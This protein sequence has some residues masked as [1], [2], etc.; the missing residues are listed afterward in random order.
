MPTEATLQEVQQF[1]L[2]ILKEVVKLCE[3][4]N[5]TYYL[6]C[7]TLIG[8]VRHKGFIPWDNDIDIEIPVEHYHR[9]LRLAKK[10]LPS[11]LFA[12][13]YTT[14]KG[15]NEMWIKVRANGTTSMPRTWRNWNIHS[16]IAIDIFPLTGI[17]Q[18]PFLRKLQLKCHS[19]CRTL[20]A[21]EFLLA[22]NP[23]EINQ[24]KKLQLIYSMPRWLRAGISR[25]LECFVFKK[26]S[27][28]KEVALIDHRITHFKSVKA[29]A[30]TNKLPFEDGLYS[31]PADPD[32]VLRA[33][34]GDYMTP[35]PE[36]V[37]NGHEW[38]F[39]EIIYSIDTDYSYYQ[40]TQ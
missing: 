12:A 25:C 34:Y 22:T 13:T 28:S 5:I 16:G 26:V 7:G 31:V 17:Y 38:C 11:H 8:A 27:S 32:H 24:N 3:R 37:R 4:H 20:L 15:Y 35:P 9:F 10:E 2:N 23:E 36:S 21:K 1:G 18:R 14:D 19:L 33:R 40:N 39:G 6:S 29:Y 30:D